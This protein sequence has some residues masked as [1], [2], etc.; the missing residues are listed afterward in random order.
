[1]FGAATWYTGYIVISSRIVHIAGA[2]TSLTLAMLGATVAHGIIYLLLRPDLPTD[3]TGW[4]AILA[5]SI[6]ATVLAMG[7]FFAGVSRIGPG[8]SAVL[9]T[10]E[11]VVSIA[12]GVTALHEE[13][14]A[15]RFVGALLVLGGVALM[16]QFSRS[17]TK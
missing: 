14:T 3:S 16:A 17:D 2:Y 7:F 15:V 11:P 8:E 12:V 13:L 5:A 4:I 1:M 9:S 10:I 6:I